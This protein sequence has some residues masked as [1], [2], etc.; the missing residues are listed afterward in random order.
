VGDRIVNQFGSCIA[1]WILLDCRDSGKKL[2]AEEAHAWYT[3]RYTKIYSQIF[4]PQ[5]CHARSEGVQKPAACVLRLFHLRLSIYREFF[6]NL[7][8]VRASHKISRAAA[9]GARE[10]ET[11]FSISLPAYQRR[12]SLSRL[13]TCRKPPPTSPR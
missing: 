4:I 3:H 6:R 2:K 7:N 9:A 8:A 13:S 11:S 5:G 1:L 10:H 12:G